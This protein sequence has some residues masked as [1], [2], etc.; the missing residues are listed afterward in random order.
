MPRL[1][2]GRR[3]G[4]VG[5][6]LLA[7]GVGAFLVV[8]SVGRSE[9]RAE[10]GER[11]RLV[12]LAILTDDTAHGRLPAAAE[13]D[14]FG[15]RLYSW[16]FEL[17]PYMIQTGLDP[18]YHDAWYAPGNR[19]FAWKYSSFYSSNNPEGRDA[20]DTCIM[21]ITGPGTAFDGAEHSLPDLPANTILC[22]EVANSGVHWMEPG[23]LDVG[24][25]PPS[26]TAG[27]DGSGF[28]VG[29]ADTEVWFL[30]RSVPLESL[31]PFL[32]IK[33]AASSDRQEI[34]G[35]YRRARIRGPVSEGAD[36]T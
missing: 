24:D 2:L 31:R 8:R 30:D 13:T 11:F 18:H 12:M 22:V 10:R 9:S 14:P 34:L 1:R 29:F 33:T 17:L 35:P 6:C 7:V 21:A 23:D 19:V 25:L 27:P 3:T 4:L 26:L 36:R 15:R 28:F 16:R 32:T 20:P 5:G